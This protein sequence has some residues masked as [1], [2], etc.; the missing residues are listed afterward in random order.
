MRAAL[1]DPAAVQDD[2]LVD[3]IESVRLVA[4]ERG[5][6]ARGDGEQAGRERGPVS[7]S[8]CAA[9]SSRI[10]TAGSASSARASASRC[11]SP[12]DMAAS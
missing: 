11:R 12:P 6:A 1:R 7:G 5:G 3:L 2:D 10:S 9:G 4:D 8:R